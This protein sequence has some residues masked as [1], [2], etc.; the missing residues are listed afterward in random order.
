MFELKTE[1]R[2]TVTPE[3]I[4][5]AFTSKNYLD[6]PATP[7]VLLLDR[8]QSGKASFAKPNNSGNG[9]TWGCHLFVPQ[10]TKAGDT[11]EIEWVYKN[12]I[13]ESDKKRTGY[14]ACARIVT[15]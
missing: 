5:S 4:R 7:K 11:L 3:A 8:R 2:V 13:T 6:F 12:Q 15:D 1:T 14:S 10:E 9:R